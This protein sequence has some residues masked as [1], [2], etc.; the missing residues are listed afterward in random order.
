LS[1]EEIPYIRFQGDDLA[2]YGTLYPFLRDKI[3]VTWD[4]NGKFYRILPRE[5]N[6]VMEEVSR[7]NLPI[8]SSLP[9]TLPEFLLP[10]S[11]STIKLTL[12]LFEFQNKALSSWIKNGYR[13]I[14]ILPTGAGKTILG[15]AA[16]EMLKVSTIV[17][18]PT[19]LLLEQWKNRLIENLSLTSEQI[20]LFGGGH[21]EIK[22]ITIS[23]FESAHLYLTRF[24]SQFGLMII[25][26]AHNL[27]G[28]N[29]EKITDGY[30]SPYRLALTATLNIRDG[31]FKVLTEKGFQKIV[32]EAFPKDLEDLDVLAPYKI[33]TIKIDKIKEENEYKKNIDILKS[34]FN[35]YHIYGLDAFEKL[36]FMVNR[37]TDAYHALQAYNVAKKIAFSA[38]DKLD[39]L[40]KLLIQHSS[41]KIIIFS[42]LVEFCERIGREFLIPVLTHRTNKEERNFIMTFFQ[43]KADAKIVVG[44]IF[45]E[46]MDVPS[47]RIGVIISGSSQTRQFIQRLGRLLRKDEEKGEAI[48]YE[49]VSKNT[50]EM[51]YSSKRKS[52]SR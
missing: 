7:Y 46:G 14:V 38:E 20:G 52:T 24:R 43:E 39:E 44:K 42:D 25:D 10:S 32:F 40:E 12:E 45:D 3:S 28:I 35:K 47:A 23:T 8:K 30:L 9:F 51:K 13:G 31:A 17:I 2:Y 36:R 48:L 18:V 29:Y 1:E 21:Q 34:F 22:P 11:Y 5:Y 26:E 6:T 49:I 41:D 4:N 15:C 16:I 27:T 50:L 37:N 19:I 33:I